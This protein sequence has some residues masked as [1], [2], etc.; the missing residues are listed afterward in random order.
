MSIK[1]VHVFYDVFMGW[2]HSSLLEVMSN[3]AGKTS[4]DKEEVALFINKSWTGVKMLAPGNTLIYH[5][6]PIITMDAIRML[7]VRFGGKRLT[8]DP[9]LEEHLLGAF[10][11][12][13]KGAKGLG[14][15]KLAYA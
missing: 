8:L 11:K 9:K 15:L 4:L 13:Q 3:S 1:C 7:P 6:A 2:S 14:N 5:R 12:R 10:D